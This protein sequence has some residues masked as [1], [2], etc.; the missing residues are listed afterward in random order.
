MPAPPSCTA[1]A[2]WMYSPTD[3]GWMLNT[4]ISAM[5]SFGKIIMHFGCRVVIDAIG[6]QPA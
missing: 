2:R 3:T 5:N 6:Q 1:V 4:W